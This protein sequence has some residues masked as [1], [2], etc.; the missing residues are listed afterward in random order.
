[1]RQKS[2]AWT[3]INACMVTL[4]DQND[5]PSVANMS[6][7]CASHVSLCDESACLQL[8]SETVIHVQKDDCLSA[9]TRHN[10]RVDTAS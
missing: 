4:L 3:V 9:N 6:Y 8:H 1:M 5:L 7:T 2:R 10:R